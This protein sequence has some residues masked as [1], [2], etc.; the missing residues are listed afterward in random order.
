MSDS[1]TNSCRRT[2]TPAA[3]VC[4]II[5]FSLKLPALCVTG[6][7]I[8]YRLRAGLCENALCW[9]AAAVACYPA[10]H[11]ARSMVEDENFA[12]TWYIFR[13][14]PLIFIALNLFMIPQHRETL[15]T[16]RVLQGYIIISVALLILPVWFNAIFLMMDNNLNKN[17]RLQQENHFHPMQHE[18]YESLKIAIE[19]ARQVR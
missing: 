8:C 6:G 5:K 13:V 7:L 2:D 15:Y 4:G 9:L 3:R 11:I 10:G 14:L 18:R 12:Q 1:G 19:D 17:A 16:G